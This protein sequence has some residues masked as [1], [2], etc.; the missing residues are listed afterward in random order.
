MLDLQWF[1][2][3]IKMTYK[4]F[5]KHVKE[6]PFIG[7][8][9][10]C[11]TGNNYWNADY[12]TM[13]VARCLAYDDYILPTK[14]HGNK[15]ADPNRIKKDAAIKKTIKTVLNNIKDS[16]DCL[17]VCE[18]GRGLDIIVANMVKEWKT[19]YCYDHVDYKTHLN[20][21][22]NVNFIQKGTGVYE[23]ELITDKYIVIMNHSIYPYDKFKKNSVH[24]IIN[25]EKIW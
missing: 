21:F 8:Q 2:R 4:E 19:I 16:A 12:W 23:P 6:N 3:L 10:Q 13:E 7:N 1:V 9:E 24:G 22:K 5:L 20:I 17:L 11:G 15:F 14:F 18:V 25:G